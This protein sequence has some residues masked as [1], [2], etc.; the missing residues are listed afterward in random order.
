[1]QHSVSQ[2]LAVVLL[3]SFG[4]D[5]PLTFDAQGV[6]HGTGEKVYNYKTGTTK[7]REEYV[8][9]KLVRSRWFRPDGTQVQETKW[10]NGTGEG[11]YLREDGSIRM[12][13]QYVNGVAEGEAKE[14]D[15]AG[16]VVKLVQYRGGQ[17]VSEGEPP[18]TKDA[19]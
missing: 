13:M 10:I 16:N 8:D 15:E 14:Y 3:C 5:R 1:M 9:G 2:L 4:C 11:I 17:R 18:A 7:L 6:A 19:S 12:R